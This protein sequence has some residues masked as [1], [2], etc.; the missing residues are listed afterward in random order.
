MGVVVVTV[1]TSAD[2]DAAKISGAMGAAQSEFIVGHAGKE[3]QRKLRA[4]P[5]GMNADPYT[6][7]IDRNGKVRANKL[8]AADKAYFVRIGRAIAG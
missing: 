5:G 3:L 7:F 4:L 8:G 1:T 2:D 6:V